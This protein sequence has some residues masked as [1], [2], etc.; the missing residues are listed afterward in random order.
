MRHSHT[1]SGLA[2]PLK[3]G[4]DTIEKSLIRRGWNAPMQIKP[5][6]YH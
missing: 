4:A 6:T 5:P 1:H 2:D 3:R